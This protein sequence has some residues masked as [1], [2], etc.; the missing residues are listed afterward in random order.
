MIWAAVEIR[1]YA[2]V[3][4]LSALLLLLFYDGYLAE[5]SRPGARWWYGLVAVLALYTQYYAGY[6]LVASACV[7]LLLKRWV[8]L[9]A[10]LLSMAA[11]GLCFVPVLSIAVN[12]VLVRRDHAANSISFI[13]DVNVIC[14]RVL[15]FLFPVNWARL[16]AKQVLSNGFGLVVAVVLLVGAVT[17][18]AAVAFRRRKVH[19]AITP[20]SIA[21]WTVTAVLVSCFIVTTRITGE[22]LTESGIW[23]LCSFR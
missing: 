21:L 11:V 17:Y 20:E 6:L 9:R 5:V 7:L 15:W 23:L 3:I 12:Q 1:L 18:V 8:A 19:R 10:Y 16:L 14:G 2:F 13:Q 4:L 22:E